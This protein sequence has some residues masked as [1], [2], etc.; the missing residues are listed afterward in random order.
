MEE[1]V[2]K[3]EKAVFYDVDELSA[4]GK[5]Q[6]ALLLLDLI[7][8][9]SPNFSMALFL[10]SM[11][12]GIIGDEE[13]SFE[14]FKKSLAEE[15]GEDAVDMEEKYVPIDMNDPN[16]LFNCGLTNFYFGDYEK[17]IENFDMSLEKLPKQSEVIYYKALSLASLGNYKKAIRTI[18][19][20][21]DINPDNSSYWNDKG[22]FHSELNHVAKAHKCFNKSIKL[23]ST[24]Y[25]WS[26]KGVLY[27]K[28]GELEK[29]MECYDNAIK[30][31]SEDVYP[32]VGKAK[33]YMELD[34]FESAEECFELAAE[35]DDC[36]LEYLIERGKYM[37]FTEEY[38]KAVSYFDRC[39][40]FNDGLAYV[41]MFK[42]MALNELRKYRQANECV[43]RAL[44]ID[45]EILVT[46]DEIF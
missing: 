25:N 29:A 10:K 42:S 35:I 41:W 43:V 3:Q 45:P 21:I 8:E 9:D 34:D 31:D 14:L 4:Q 24:S 46:F 5:L 33:V 37:I 17:A 18:N 40:K 12:L 44:E 22:A 36:D 2:E 20:A 28:C 11:F 26:N 23:K 15:L 30:L 1:Q 19:K 27:H 13:E 38:E 32:V 7:P 39:L 16:D 6:E